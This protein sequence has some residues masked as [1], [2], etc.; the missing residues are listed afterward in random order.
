MVLRVP[1]KDLS[2]MKDAFK[3][4]YHAPELD[5]A[6]VVARVRVRAIAGANAH[7]LRIWL[8]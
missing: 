3:E 2:L 8:P 5:A 1:K 6:I 4:P 7:G